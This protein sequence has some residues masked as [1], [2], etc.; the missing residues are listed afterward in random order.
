MAIAIRLARHGQKKR[1]F[2]RIVA[3]EKAARRDGRFH[4]IVGTYNP[5]V[6][7]P[8]VNLKEDK[9]RRWVMDGAKPTQVVRDLINKNFPD[10]LKGKDEHQRNKI[11]ARRAN[12]RAKMKAKKAASK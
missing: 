2:Y 3:T 1:P 7:P 8:A 10:L 12:R 5:M 11:V 4:E 6:N 9:I